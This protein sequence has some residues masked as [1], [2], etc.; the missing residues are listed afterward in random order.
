MATSIEATSSTSSGYLDIIKQSLRE[1]LEKSVV[2]TNVN[3]TLE[4]LKERKREKGTWKT[5]ELDEKEKIG[6][7]DKIRNAL[8]CMEY[9]EDGNFMVSQ[10]FSK[11]QGW[12]LA[13]S[14]IKAPPRTV[15]SPE[16]TVTTKTGEKVVF[17]F[18]LDKR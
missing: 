1:T 10:A 14:V 17:L 6:I 12:T 7:E 13:I 8:G 3:L 9:T 18:V 11:A 4:G 15:I 16:R 2:L 5:E